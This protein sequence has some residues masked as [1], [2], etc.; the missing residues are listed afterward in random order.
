MI[1]H[2]SCA[3]NIAA[4]AYRSQALNEAITERF[5]CSKYMV[6]LSAHFYGVRRK[7]SI[8]KPLEEPSYF[9][10]ITMLLGNGRPTQPAVLGYLRSEIKQTFI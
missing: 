6:D 2:R 7:F 3:D 8:T 1:S 5:D 10:V 9:R 4:E